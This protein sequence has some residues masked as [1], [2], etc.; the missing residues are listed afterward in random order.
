MPSLVA[1]AFDPPPPMPVI[2]I[3][4]P[5]PVD[6]IKPPDILTPRF[7]VPFPFKPPA[8]PVTVTRPPAEAILPVPKP[9]VPR[10]T[11]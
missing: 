11:P 10:P 7:S 1:V 4:V 3:S 2:V 9:S 5:L 6:V 8:V